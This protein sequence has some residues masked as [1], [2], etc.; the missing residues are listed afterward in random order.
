MQV[1]GE[2]AWAWAG[3]VDFDMDRVRVRDQDLRVDMDMVVGR[4]VERV[5]MR[6]S[7]RAGEACALV[8]TCPLAC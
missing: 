2:R 3:C 7:E 5:G 1:D 4:P 8:P 6:V